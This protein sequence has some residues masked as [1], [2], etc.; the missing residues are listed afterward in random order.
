MPIELEHKNKLVGKSFPWRAEENALSSTRGGMLF[1]T[2]GHQ[3]LFVKVRNNGTS[4][5]YV[6]SVVS[7]CRNIDTM[8]WT[9]IGMVKEVSPRY[10]IENYPE[11][12]SV[13]SK[14]RAWRASFY[15]LLVK[16]VV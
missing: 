15:C 2:P 4:I 3:F 7:V 14:I 12:I 6:E 8:D 11:I 10:I 1:T 13:F 9:L 16:P 5:N